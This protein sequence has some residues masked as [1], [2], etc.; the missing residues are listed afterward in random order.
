[1]S[2]EVFK[3][4]L[5]IRE[6]HLDTFG[7]MNNARYLEI[8]EEARWEIVTSKGFGLKDVQKTGLGPI[9]LEVNLKFKRE[10]ALRE[11]IIIES[12]TQSYRGK[13]A[14]M[15]QWIKK[16]DGKVATEMDL[17]FGLFDTR[18]RKLVPPTPEW[19]HAIGAE[20]L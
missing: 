19:L 9:I 1:M 16:N 2:A 14:H 10:I 18:Q 13:I 8:F 4:P 11:Q 5:L 12:Q 17:T 6:S 7:H 20:Y 15:K 3:Y